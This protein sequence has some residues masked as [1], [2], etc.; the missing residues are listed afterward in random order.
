MAPLRVHLIELGSLGPTPNFYVAEGLD[1]G[2][3]PL[4]ALRLDPQGPLSIKQLRE[5]GIEPTLHTLY[6]TR[7]YPM[8]YYHAGIGCG[9]W[10]RVREALIKAG[11]PDIC[12][13]QCAPTELVHKSANDDRTELFYL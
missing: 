4:K 6:S 7:L 2:G 10:V 12:L 3:A 5:K 9:S 11:Y 1:G 8:Y 13:Y